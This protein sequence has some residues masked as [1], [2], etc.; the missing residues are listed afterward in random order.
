MVT[1]GLI[2]S[3]V[4][5]VDISADEFNEENGIRFLREQLTEIRVDRHGECAE[6][7]MKISP[8]ALLQCPCQSN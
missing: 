8:I 3:N 6:F 1:I 5:R 4:I 2:V 7:P